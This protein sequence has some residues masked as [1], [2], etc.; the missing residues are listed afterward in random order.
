M[1][2]LVVDDQELNRVLLQFLLQDEGYEV[3]IATNGEEALERFDDNE[4]DLVLLD[5][6][7]PVMDGFATAPLLKEKAGEL[8]LPII[9]ITALDDQASLKRCLEVGGDDFLNKPF[10][11]VILSAKI[12]AHARIR[13]L[14]LKTLEQKKQLEYH[15][16]QINRE[17][18]IVDHVFKNALMDNYQDKEVV[19]FY[20]SPHSMFNGDVLLIATNPVGG[21]YV[22]MG[23]FTGHG[24]SAAI[25]ALPLSKTFYS[26]AKK[27]L[28]VGDMAAELNN[29]LLQLLPDDM[30]CAATILEMNS[31]GK[32]ISLW[33]G[34]M[35]DTFLVKPDGTLNKII[36]SQH[37]ALGVLEADE[38][39]TTVLNIETNPGDR[40]VLYTDGI[41]ESVNLEGEMYSET[42]FEDFFQADKDTSI[43]TLINELIAFR[44]EAEQNDDISMAYLTCTNKLQA[45]VEPEQSFSKLP[46]HLR[47]EATAEEL[48]HTDPVVEMLDVVSQICGLSDHRSVMFLLL[49]EVYNNAL[50]HGILKLDSSD[51]DGDDGFMDYYFKRQDALSAL[52]QGD[53]TINAEYQPNGNRII[54]T[55]T[56][57]GD[58]FDMSSTSDNTVNDKEHGRGLSL[59]AELAESI[60]YSDKGN[61]VRVVYLL[62]A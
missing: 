7:M 8:Y 41:I 9:F 50:D 28:S 62:E 52:T 27:G 18:E 59:L 47:L 19:D 34:G 2:V 57:S 45:M 42:R 43:E 23:D 11:K 26:M 38:F 46:F 4:I 16:N 51:K 54:F 58:G 12:R 21:I 3:V 24:L 60:E 32:S 29:Q 14:A 53:I 10:D 22:L 36:N 17:H 55:I 31:S 49:S 40:V 39:E 35:P 33:I 20:M 1:R 61:E 56:D 13:A 44:G 25:G 6:V 30:F 48:K 5:V 15:Q 37:M